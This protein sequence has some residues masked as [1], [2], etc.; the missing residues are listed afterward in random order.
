MGPQGAEELAGRAAFAQAYR[1][2]AGTTHRAAFA[3]LGDDELARDVTQDVFLRLWR[4]PEA[5]DPGRADL[6]AYLRLRA[7]SRALDVWR[8]HE[9]AQR[10]LA[11]LGD[12][13]AATRGPV[14]PEESPAAAAEHHHDRAA[15]LAAVRRLPAPQREAVVLAY[16]AGL[17]AD[18]V[19]Q[20]VRVPLGT[21]KSRIRLGVR[22]LGHECR[23]ELA[24]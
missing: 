4:C 22:R 13:Q 24:A 6:A 8:R 11:R 12:A 14:A 9:A 2:H 5:Y 7:R 17:T 15:L 16:W 18:E 3:I 23:A 10:A 1:R 20:R 21:A 19:S